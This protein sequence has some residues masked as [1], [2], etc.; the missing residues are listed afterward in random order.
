LFHA[1]RWENEERM[2][3]QIGQKAH[4]FG[5]PIGLLTDCHRRI[6]MFLEALRVV[7]ARARG[8]ELNQ[9]QRQALSGA[10]HYFRESAPKHTADEELSL[11]PRMRAAGGAEIEA[12]LQEM[13]RLE[14]DHVRADRLHREV[15]RLGE[16]WLRDGRLP[17]ESMDRLIGH[18]DELSAMY[19]S[20]IALEDGRIF[21]VAARVLSADMQE[22]IG[23]EMAGRRFS[24]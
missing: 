18:L 15:D 2:P 6:E 14:S 11:F 17:G 19:A 10:L 9:E 16:A 21:P 12:V 22:A 4:H 5:Q 24:T 13:E 20:H 7:A 1:D 3:V 8:G 23:K